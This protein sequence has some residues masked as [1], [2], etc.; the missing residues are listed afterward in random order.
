MELNNKLGEVYRFALHKHSGQSYGNY[1]YIYHLLQVQGFALKM[2]LSEEYQ[3]VA[4]LHDILED[5]ETTYQEL[6][7][8][9]GESVAN[10]VLELTHD[11]HENYLDYLKGLSI[12]ARK[13]KICDIMCNL[14][15]SI[16][17]GNQ[18]LID[19]YQ[20]ALFFLATN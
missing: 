6:C 3:I 19:K 20:K 2:N 16:L 13:V 11:K 15:E 12:P 17:I 14:Q 4:L 18:R 1:P 10:C 8:N 7:D 9:F 5:T